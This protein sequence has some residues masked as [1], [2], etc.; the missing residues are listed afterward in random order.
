[1]D[2]E[3]YAAFIAGAVS[4]ARA[5]ADFFNNP[6]YHDLTDA[7]IINAVQLYK[8]RDLW[9]GRH[10]GDH[11]QADMALCNEL[12][13]WC[14]PDPERIDALFRESGLYRGKWERE[15]YRRRTIAKACCRAS[16]IGWDQPVPRG[17]RARRAS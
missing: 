15:D 7:E 13:R 14:G 6:P 12:A 4:A 2:D 9:C 16:F 5:E 11:S 1:M 10:V 8:G 3:Q 17:V